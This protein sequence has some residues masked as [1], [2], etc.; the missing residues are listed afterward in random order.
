VSQR[1]GQ[2]CASGAICYLSAPKDSD[3]VRSHVVVINGWKFAEKIVA[4]YMY[5]YGALF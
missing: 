1:Q 4:G 5:M 2:R 3:S